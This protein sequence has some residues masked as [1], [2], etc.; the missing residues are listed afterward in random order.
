MR[1]QKKAR[2]ALAIFIVAF[3]AVVFLALRRPHPEAPAGEALS[4]DRSALVQTLGPAVL[5]RRDEAGRLQFSINSTGQKAYENGRNVFEH[6]TVTLPDR[7]GRDI[8]ITAPEAEVVKP[9]AGESELSTA[10]LRGG[11]KLVTS[12]GLIVNATEATYN[13]ADGILN[14]PGPVT[15]SRAR[16]KGSGVGATYDRN[17][18]VLWLLADAHIDVAADAQGAGAIQG[19]SGT[20]GLA[21]ADH[22]LR[23]SQDAHLVSSDRTIDCDDLTVRLTPDDERVQSMALRGSSRIVGT[24]AGAS[25]MSARDIDLAYGEDGRALQS[26]K[27]RENSVLD[28]PGDTAARRRITGRFIDV[29]MAPDGATV[30]QLAASEQVVVDL[31]GQGGGPA[32]TIR[33][34]T[35]TAIGEGG[36][37][38]QTATFQGPVDFRETTAGAKG[39]GNPS[40]R[41]TS[42]QLQVKTEPGLGAIQEAEFRGRVK[43]EDAPSTTAAAS[44][45]LYRIADD[46][47]DLFSDTSYPGPPPNVSDGRLT[48]FA[49]T[50]QMTLGTHVLNADT[51]VRSRLERKAGPDAAETDT[52]MPSLLDGDQPVTVT[53]NRLAYDGAASK[54]VF[55][56]NAR[57][58]QDRTEIKG[59]TIE[60]DD[61]QGN[62]TATGAVSTR[63]MMQDTDPKTGRKTPTETNGSGETF[64]YE[65]ARRL[66]LYTSSAERRA[67][68]IGAQGDITGDRIELY[69][70]PEVRELQRA[71][72]DGDVITIEGNRT[73][74]GKHLTYTAA[75]ET[76]VMTGSPVDVLEAKPNSCKRTLA[77]TVRFQR[78]QDSV[79]TEGKPVT[80]NTVPCPGTPD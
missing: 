5:E 56:G 25:S 35:L 33:A 60:L 9:A 63:M 4:I 2:L 53:S 75:D 22:Y 80:V 69:L 40:R 66:A 52:K 58:V 20:A 6:A 3:A 39:K 71:E 13:D 59:S 54:A 19:T 41:A 65:D 21:R 48:V 72:A 49:G 44:R 62:L 16:L 51:D 73:A 38:L 76:Y 14:I 17:R 79:T 7:N 29:T 32:R 36:S 64:V 30:T 27:L 24:G 10:V 78:A 11:V 47:L 50:I 61:R 74:R 34:S 55:T 23:M 12:D 28:L 1:W 46:R 26:A 70:K 57:L 42:D 15:F 8:V 68:V 77:A 37:G 43:F 67:H 45:A 18:D 31:P